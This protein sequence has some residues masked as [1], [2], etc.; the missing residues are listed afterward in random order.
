MAIPIGFVISF[1]GNVSDA[2]SRSKYESQGWYL[3]DGRT[4]SQTTY[5]KLFAA[6]GTLYGGD[7]TSFKLPDYRGMFLRGQAQGSVYRD[8]DAPRRYLQGD[9]STVVGDA[10]GSWQLDGLGF[11][12]HSLTGTWGIQRSPSHHE[13]K[14]DN[15][16]TGDSAGA[17]ETVGS[18]HETRPK[19]VNVNY[20]VF[21]DILN[22]ED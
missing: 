4:F 5:P 17:T 20:L 15:P 18:G 13:C 8:W 7:D 21:G 10:V 16:F 14:S 3:C 22:S 9:P 1:A 12:S 11:H 19:N 2:N 6:L